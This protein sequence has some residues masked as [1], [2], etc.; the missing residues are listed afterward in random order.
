MAVNC[1]GNRLPQN[2][3][4]QDTVKFLVWDQF[5]SILEQQI[6]FTPVLPMSGKYQHIRPGIKPFDRA[7][8]EA[9]GRDLTLSGIGSLIDLNKYGNTLQR[10]LPQLAGTPCGTNSLCLEPVCYGFTEGVIESNNF[11]HQICWSLSMPC[12]KDSLYSDRMFETKMKRYFAVFFRQGP[13]ALEAF[14]RTKLIFEA[15]KVVCTDKN[16]LIGSTTGLS[17]PFYINANDPYSMPDLAGMGAN[18]GGVNLEALAAYV[19]PRLFSN[20]FFAGQNNVKVYGLQSDYLMAKSQSMT[21]MDYSGDGRLVADRMIDQSLGSFVADQLFPTFK[22]VGTQIVPISAEVLEPSTIA[23][24]VQTSNPEHNVAPIR[25]LLFVPE[26]SGFELVAPPED[27]F[28]YLG[29]GEGLNFRTNTPGVFPILSSSMFANNTIGQDGTVVL[30]TGPDGRMNATGLVRRS[31]PLAEAIRS[32]IIMTY[33][34]P[35]CSNTA[36]GQLANV[37]PAVVQQGRADGFLAKSTMYIKDSFYGTA[38]PVLVLFAADTPRV[39]RPITSCS[40]VEVEIETDDCNDIVSAC[41]GGTTFLVIQFADA[42]GDAFEE[43]DAVVYRTGPRGSSYLA[44]VVSVDGSSVSI[45]SDD[46]E[47]ALPACAGQDQYGLQG[48]LINLEGVTN[49]T[50]GVMKVGVDGTSIILELFDAIGATLNNAAGTLTLNTGQV[51]NIL[52]DGNQGAGV[53]LKIKAAVGE[54]CVLTT[55]DCSCLV[56]A[57]LVLA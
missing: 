8:L 34:N 21:A 1:A 27:D 13:A 46:P 24:F 55:L 7:I 41:P 26:S 36:A 33:T 2:L 16:F 18:I 37:G 38:K 12:L 57:V 47:V 48:Q 11:T 28:S 14:Q 31:R 32:E 44:T 6:K 30:G 39:A 23:G 5:P 19:L 9:T 15:V 4:Y 25:G 3:S 20:A 35:S 53:Y 43:D 52:V 51:V 42:V 17:L 29:M 49:K 56:D 10:P 50:S 54:T 22:L 45:E 40:V